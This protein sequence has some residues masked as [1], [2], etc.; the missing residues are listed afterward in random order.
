MYK[1]FVRNWWR[2]ENG[3][4]VPDPGARKLTL[5]YVS[6]EN[7]AREICRDYNNSHNPGELSRK[8]EYTSIY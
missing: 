7:E 2:K 4:L 1:V 8:A 5:D 3:K 6:T